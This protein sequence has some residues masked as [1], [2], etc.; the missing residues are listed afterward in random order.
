MRRLKL[1]ALA[2]AQERALRDRSHDEELRNQRAPLYAYLL[3]WTDNLLSALDQITVEH[4]ELPKSLWHI[5]P[6]MEDSLDL[7]S[8]D[9]VHIHFNS[10]RGLLI[11]LVSNSGF[12][13]SPIV[14]WDEENGR[15]SN[16]SITRTRPLANWPARERILKKAQ[17][18]A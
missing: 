4:P 9:S 5:E 7:Y 12:S 8:S 16:V 3:R 10:L 14:T 2:A 13:D 6:T 11:G 1:S 17:S 15:I 18:L